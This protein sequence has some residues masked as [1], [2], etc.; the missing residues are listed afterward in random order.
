MIKGLEASLNI[1]C[2]E[3]LLKNS[4]VLEKLKEELVLQLNL[5]EQ[6]VKGKDIQLEVINGNINF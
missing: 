4:I 6:H 1:L 3:T 5:Y 2:T